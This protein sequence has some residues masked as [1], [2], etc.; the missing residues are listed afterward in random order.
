MHFLHK[1]GVNLKSTLL[2]AGLAFSAIATP[3]LAD[4]SPV[5]AGEDSSGFYASIGAGSALAMDE[6]NFKETGTLDKSLD[7]DNVI[8]GEIGLGYRVNENLRTEISYSQTSFWLEDT[9]HPYFDINNVNASSYMIN[10]YYDMPELLGGQIVPY[11]G[12]GWGYST[13]S[14][15]AVHHAGTSQPKTGPQEDSTQTWIVKTGLSYPMWHNTDLFGEVSYHSIVSD[16]YL[17]HKDFDGM[18]AVKGQ[19]GIRLLF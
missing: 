1:M 6:I 17:G 19:L 2:A 8:N 4:I 16:T 7:T 15:D 5:K 18:S 12:A 14:T 10:A 9:S 11:V 13:L 3:G